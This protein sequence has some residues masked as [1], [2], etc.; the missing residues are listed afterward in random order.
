MNRKTIVKHL[1]EIVRTIV[2]AEDRLTPAQDRAVRAVI[3]ELQHPP[4]EE[5]LK[6]CFPWL[7]TDDA[8]DYR[9][10]CVRLAEWYKELTK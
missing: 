8:I 5:Q 3:A 4:I 2:D 10:E 6:T 9:D 1:K 7:G